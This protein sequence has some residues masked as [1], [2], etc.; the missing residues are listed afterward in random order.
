MLKLPRFWLPEIDRV[1]H[2]YRTASGAPARPDPARPTLHSVH[3]DLVPGNPLAENEHF[4]EDSSLS[5]WPISGP[6][7]V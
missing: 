7:K 3:L 6:D 5:N 1:N 4:S 2:F